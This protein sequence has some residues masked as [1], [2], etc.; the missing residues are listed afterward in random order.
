MIIIFVLFGILIFLTSS[1]ALGPLY[2]YFILMTREKAFET[3]LVL[4]LASLIISLWL[5]VE[6]LEYV[7]IAFLVIGIVS[8][9]ISMEIAKVWLAFSHYLGLVMNFVLMFIIFL[10][11]LIPLAQLQRLFGSNHIRRK[12][13]E[14]TYFH[15][16]NHHY[17]SK[18]IDN[19][20]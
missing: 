5:N 8:K 6:W 2:L 7:A 15:Q 11:I 10:F 18:D 16:R 20:W 17:S 3:I 12:T 14:N 9:R 1:S 19:P 13:T 4:A